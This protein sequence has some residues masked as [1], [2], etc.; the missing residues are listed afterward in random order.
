MNIVL[1]VKTY[2]SYKQLEE[3][4]VLNCCQT[5]KKCYEKMYIFIGI[6]YILRKKLEDSSFTAKEGPLGDHCRSYI[7][8]TTFSFQNFYSKINTSKRECLICHM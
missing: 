6:T 5:T 1:I 8:F 3:H 7:F 4:E 2:H